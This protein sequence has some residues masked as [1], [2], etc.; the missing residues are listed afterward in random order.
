MIHVVFNEAGYKVLQQA[1]EL[2]ASMLGSILIIKDNFAVGPIAN[3]YETEGY[4]LRREWWKQLLVNTPNEQ[5]GQLADDKLTVHQLLKTLN[6]QPEEEVWLWMAQNTRDVCGYYWLVGQ[7]ASFQGRVQ[8]LYLNNLPFFN[9]KGA[10]FYPTQLGEI[11]PKEFLKAK[12][13]A[14]CITAS[15]FEL[16]P[17]EWAKLCVENAVLRLLEGGKKIVGKNANYFD[18]PIMECL[19]SEPQKMYKVLQ[20]FTNKYPLPIEDTFW[21]WRL[22]AL[23][24]TSKV[25]VVDHTKKDWKDMT[26]QLA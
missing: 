3:I 25:L 20:T 17:E 24:A 15:E 1:F 8:V 12:K 14:R 21:I 7:L 23:V 16:D 6:D 11:Q 19:S 18:K 26:I 9:E 22:N 4:Q 2:D 5:Q 13:L 10:L